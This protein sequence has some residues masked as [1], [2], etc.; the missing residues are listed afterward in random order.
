MRAALYALII[1]AVIAGGYFLWWSHMADEMLLGAQN[2]EQQRKM[3]GYEISHSPYEL[4]GFPYR[5]KLSARDISIRNP[6]HKAAPEL[7][8]ESFWLLVQPWNITRFIFG[9]NE[10]LSASWR[11]DADPRV[12]SLEPEKLLGSGHFSLDGKFKNLALDLEKSRIEFNWRPPVFITR[13]QVHGRPAPQSENANIQIAVQIDNMEMAE[14]EDFA[15]GAIVETLDITGVVR[16]KTPRGDLNSS[17]QTWRDEGGVIELEKIDVIWGP[18]TIKADGTLT[19]D[20]L[21]RPLGAFSATITGYRKIMQA[22]AMSGRMPV[23]TAATA[24]F[25]LDLLART[26]E[27]GVKSLTLPVTAQDGGL[28]LGPVKLTQLAPVFGH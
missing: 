16:G 27:K 14:T 1:F 24:V 18:T 4:S 6:G 8:M 17:L 25:G 10:K 7:K 11:Q 20:E 13:A 3:E 9:T 23:Q 26:D 22:L 19:L 28:Y 2:W 12:I 5:I 21:M 15:L